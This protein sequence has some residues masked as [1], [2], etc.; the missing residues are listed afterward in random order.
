MKSKNQE[1]DLP[2]LKLKKAKHGA[3]KYKTLCNN[4]YY[5]KNYQMT[6]KIPNLDP[7]DRGKEEGASTHYMGDQS[8]MPV[9]YESTMIRRND[10]LSSMTEGFNSSKLSQI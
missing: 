4:I 1:I 8:T 10:D 6:Y 2:K 5:D 7:F 3:N 9:T